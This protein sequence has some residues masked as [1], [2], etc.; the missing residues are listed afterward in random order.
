MMGSRREFHRGLPAGNQPILYGMD[1]AEKCDPGGSQA[2][3]RSN[4]PQENQGDTHLADGG[5]L[6]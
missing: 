2:C 5:F 6:R 3:Q 4:I 1:Q